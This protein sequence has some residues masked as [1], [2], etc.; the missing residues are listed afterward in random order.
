MASPVNVTNSNIISSVFQGDQSFAQQAGLRVFI[1]GV[2]SLVGHSLFEELR[3]DHLAIHSGE[4]PR[5]F[6]GSL[7]EQ[8]PVAAPSQTI[9]LLNCKTKPKTFAKLVAK[10]DVLVLNLTAPT[11]DCGEAE[12]AIK[13]LRQAEAQQERVLLVLS[14]PATW[15]HTPKKLK[16]NFPR[17]RPEDSE[18]EDARRPREDESDSEGR[19]PA[20][21]PPEGE[22]VLYFTDKEFKARV[23][24]PRYQ[25]IKN[26]EMLAMAAQKAVKSLRV[27]VIC[28]G[29]LY[30]NGE[31]VFYEFF[32]RAWLSLHPD[33]ASL[34]VLGAGTNRIPTIHALDLA[35]CIKHLIFNGGLSSQYLIAVD[36]ARRQTQ[37][38][39]MKAISRGL[40]SG[41][42]KTVDLSDVVDEDWSEAL[43]LDLKL[44]P[45]AVFDQIDW[46]CPAGLSK[47]SMPLLNQEF[48][49]FR[50]LFPLKVFVTGP[51]A[52]GKTHYA[53]VLAKNYGVPHLK[54][55]DL[56][57]LGYKLQ[58]A[59][60]D[61]IRRKAEEIKDQVVAD[62]EKTK[63]KK[64]PELDR[65]AIKV[66]LPD[67]ILHRLVRMQL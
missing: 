4:A 34:P 11:C 37:K 43:S 35:R 60:G 40:G 50:G 66:R 6:F 62:Y 54:I 53:Q 1:S 51:P 52:S 44:K 27:H 65:S 25:Q 64:D 47:A 58:D 39:I 14:P 55:A 29:L 12:L 42:T 20:K 16:K 32:R 17:P 24:P 7:N 3:N 36:K 19:D 13:S 46:H 26:V 10:C 45:S 49:T 28:T 38:K 9:K 33:L 18:A 59:F 8:E 61:E 56:V 31:S 22:K 30:G 41:L 63:K 67:E 2:N 23:P 15:A 57:A 48:N 5:R 21:R